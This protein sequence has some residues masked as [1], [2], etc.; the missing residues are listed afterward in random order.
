MQPSTLII[1]LEATM[2]DRSSPS[3]N[4][5]RE[6][7]SGTVQLMNIPNICRSHDCSYAAQ[8][9]VAVPVSRLQTSARAFRLQT[10]QIQIPHFPSSQPVQ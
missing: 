9:Y 7:D 8:E 4:S 10:R 6:S 5:P 1:S 3:R 2:G